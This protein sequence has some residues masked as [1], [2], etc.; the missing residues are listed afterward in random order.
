MRWENLLSVFGKH[1]DR[2]RDEVKEIEPRS[3]TEREAAWIR[4]ILQANEEW[5]DADISGTQV[6]AEGPSYEGI[7]IVLRASEPENPKAKSMRESV[8]NL[9]I[10][11]DDG[12]VINVQLSQFHGRLQELYVLFIDTKH[13]KRKLPET[14][15]EVSREAA[16]M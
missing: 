15:T 12:S 4:D 8:G 13:P 10:Q 6:V 3:L 14:W 11:V 7:S 1:S 5:R 9:W 16:N 2:D